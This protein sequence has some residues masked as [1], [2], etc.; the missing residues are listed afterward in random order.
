MA[1]KETGSL[2]VVATDAGAGVAVVTFGV[3][4]T[5][6][7]AGGEVF[8][9]PPRNKFLTR[10]LRLGAGF[11]NTCAAVGPPRP[12]GAPSGLR[13]GGVVVPARTGN[14]SAFGTRC[15]GRATGLPLGRA[16]FTPFSG[17]P[18]L[19]GPAR[20][21]LED[22]ELVV[23]SLPRPRCGSC[24][25]H[26]ILPNAGYSWRLTSRTFKLAKPSSRPFTAPLPLAWAPFTPFT[27]LAWT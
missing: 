23:R 19:P 6:A 27:L 15:L 4:L 14:S 18:G 7:S 21:W 22:A 13:A 2:G 12:A 16:P 17:R 1:A 3:A 26:E 10:S 9:A 24:V 25:C 20:A 11:C 5:G 8:G